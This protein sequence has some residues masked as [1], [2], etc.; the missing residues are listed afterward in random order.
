MHCNNQPGQMRDDHTREKEGH[1]GVQGLKAVAGEITTV[2]GGRGQLKRGWCRSKRG[3]QG[4][5]QQK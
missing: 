3:Q 5:W 1:H 2:E 4:S